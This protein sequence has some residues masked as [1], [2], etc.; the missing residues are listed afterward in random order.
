MMYASRSKA[1]LGNRK[2]TAFFSQQIVHRDS[3]VFEKHLAMTFVI[4]IS[5]DWKATLNRHSRCVFRDKNHALLPISIRRIWFGLAHHNEN[6]TAFAGCS[7]NPPF[8]AIEHILVAIAFDCE[9]DVGSVG[10]GYI[11]VGHGESRA[12]LTIEPVRYP[13]FLLPWALTL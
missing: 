2:T 6:F 13:P 3:N 12:D 4:Y 8:A 5:H 7:R 10:T 11:R 9:L 1:R